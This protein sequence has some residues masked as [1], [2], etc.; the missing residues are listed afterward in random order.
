MNKDVPSHN[1]DACFN[2]FSS[3]PKYLLMPTGKIYFKKVIVTGWHNLDQTSNPAW[4]V[5]KW[6]LNSH[7][8]SGSSHVCWSSYLQVVF[9]WT[10]LGRSGVFHTSPGSA[11]GGI[12]FCVDKWIF[13]YWQSIYLYLLVP[14]PVLVYFLMWNNDFKRCWRV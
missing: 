13:G 9:R 3:A 12:S 1:R 14:V 2:A 8:F 11:Q 7:C 10:G 6:F 5:F 4:F